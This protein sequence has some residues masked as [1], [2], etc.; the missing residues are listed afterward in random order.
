MTDDK[1]PIFT[2]W[3]Q[4]YWILIGV[5]VLQVVVYYWLTQSFV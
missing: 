5:L 2:T 3:R 4:W 1:P